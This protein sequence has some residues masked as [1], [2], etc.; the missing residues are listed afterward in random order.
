MEAKAALRVAAELS[1][2]LG[3]RL[4]V[5]YVAQAAVFA[6]GVRPDPVVAPADEEEL[7]T[8][9]VLLAR[10]VIDQGVVDSEQRSLCGF[11][12]EGLADLA[13]EE[14]AAFIV[15]GSRGRGAFRAAFLG[16][17]SRNLIGVARCP[18][19]VVPPGAVEFTR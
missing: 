6:S 19:L 9:E 4:V 10:I 17:V 12:A 18:V 5:A 7:H 11:P 8:G 15:V 14:D 3:L 1:E 2:Q 16:S 13:D